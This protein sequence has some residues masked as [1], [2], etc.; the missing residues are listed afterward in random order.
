MVVLKEQVETTVTTLTD[1]S[2]FG[3]IALVLSERRSASVAAGTACDILVLHRRELFLTLNDYLRRNFQLFRL[4]ATYEIKEDIE[5]VCERLQPRRQCV[6][7]ALPRRALA[8][9][10]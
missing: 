6:L 9:Q 3:E 2:F 4:E 8:R 1:G 10:W 7:R 5:D